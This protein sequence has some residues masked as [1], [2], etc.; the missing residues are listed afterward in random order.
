[1]PL[2]RGKSRKVIGRNIK[3]MEASGRPHDQAVAAALDTARRSGARIPKRR[4][5]R[6]GRAI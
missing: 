2:L 5:G 4:K 1:M 3:E 6:H